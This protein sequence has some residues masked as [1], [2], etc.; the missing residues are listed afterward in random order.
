MAARISGTDHLARPA[1]AAPALEDEVRH[2]KR[3]A[4]GAPAS[5]DRFELSCSAGPGLA[6]LSEAGAGPQLPEGPRSTGV[7]A[8]GGMTCSVGGAA[9]GTPSSRGDRLAAGMG[10]QGSGRVRLSDDL[11][12]HAQPQVIRNVVATAL[13]GARFRE[14]GIAGVVV[15]PASATPEQRAQL[16]GESVVKKLLTDPTGRM[17]YDSFKQA[18]PD[19]T[20]ELV[21]EIVGPALVGFNGGGKRVGE[22]VVDVEPELAAIGE[23]LSKWHQ[24]RSHAS[25]AGDQAAPEQAQLQQLTQA[26]F[27]ASYAMVAV[28]AHEQGSATVSLQSVD[29]DSSFDANASWR[30][31]ERGVGRRSGLLDSQLDA[32]SEPIEADGDSSSGG[33]MLDERPSYGTDPSQLRQQAAQIAEALHDAQKQRQRN[34]DK[35][36]AVRQAGSEAV[37]QAQLDGAEVVR[38][39][40]QQ[41]GDPSAPRRAPVRSRTPQG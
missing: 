39:E 40:R 29:F 41:D 16:L 7:M 19:L 5:A 13:N 20:P 8:G 34:A 24:R 2:G 32:A 4:P 37:R 25:G 15:S 12:G 1:V 31:A 23:L 21:A 10:R 38:A 30:K 28:L 35:T 27:D 11:Q 18:Y 26:A 3:A 22:Y 17:L 33:G 36:D 14:L 6:G 9:A